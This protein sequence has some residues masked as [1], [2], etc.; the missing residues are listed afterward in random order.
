MAADHTYLLP[1]RVS[2]D[3]EGLE[4]S[5]EVRYITVTNPSVCYQAIDHAKMSIAFCN[6]Q[7][8]EPNTAYSM[9]DG[10]ETTYWRSRVMP[11]TADRNKWLASAINDDYIYPDDDGL[12][13]NQSYGLNRNSWGAH[14]PG[15]Y[16]IHRTPNITVV[17]DLGQTATISGVRLSK[18]NALVQTIKTVDFSVA[19]IFFQN[20]TRYSRP[21]TTLPTASNTETTLPCGCQWP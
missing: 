4:V 8:P 10:N 16:G 5:D 9:I 7:Q 17:T 18:L 12:Y 13:V 14:S 21:T 11:T 2:T 19:E 1:L 15:C 3:N 6:S 20:H